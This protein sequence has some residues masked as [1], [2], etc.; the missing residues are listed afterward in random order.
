MARHAMPVTPM[1]IDF[2]SGHCLNLK[3]IPIEHAE[4]ALFR[5][6]FGA[7]P[8]VGNFGPAR[9]RS[10]AIVPPAGGFVIAIAAIE[11]VIAAEQFNPTAISACKA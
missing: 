4:V 9:D 5:S 6:A 10:D 3:A 8:A 2:S 7:Y 11:A 1:R